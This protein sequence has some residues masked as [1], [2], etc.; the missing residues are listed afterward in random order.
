M[1]EQCRMLALLWNALLEMNERLY[2][3]IGGQ[4]GVVHKGEGAFAKNGRWRPTEKTLLTHFDMLKEITTLRRECQEWRQFSSWTGNRVA[5][6]LEQAFKGFFRRAKEGA[7]ASSG[8]PKYRSTRKANWIPHIFYS[9]IKLKPSEGISKKKWRLELPGI[10]GRIRAEGKFPSQPLNWTNSDIR[11]MQGS[12]WLSVCVDTA[13]RR[14][15][16]D[17]AASVRFDLVDTFADVKGGVA[18]PSWGDILTMQERL[19]ALKAERDTRFPR[20]PG[21]RPSLNWR[22]TSQRIGKLSARIA[23]VRRERLHEWTTAV[24][25]QTSDLTVVAP[26]VRETTQSAK[27]DEKNWGAAVGTVAAVNR[28]VLSQ[29]PASAVQMLEYKAKEAGIRCDII[30][31]EAPATAIGAAIAD[32][33]RE[34]RRVSRKVRKEDRYADRNRQHPPDHRKGNESA[35]PL[36]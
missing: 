34:L 22:R 1:L 25:R 8:Y 23:R 4:K 36:G 15:P 30:E 18:P 21:Q 26:P 3:R 11:Q 13:K 33:G 27:G 35:R 24:T 20:K 16:G 5:F 17:R 19:D 2:Q 9:G 29:A 10:P 6:A 12:W 7:G 28:H 32:A 31:D 14:E